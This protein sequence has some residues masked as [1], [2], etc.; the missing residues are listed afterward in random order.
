MCSISA[1]K[2]F[3][4]FQILSRYMINNS[5][6]YYYYITEFVIFRCIFTL[7]NIYFLFI[8]SWIRIAWSFFIVYFCTRT[9]SLIKFKRE[10]KRG[11]V[12][13]LGHRHS[14]IY[15]WY[16]FIYLFVALVL[17][18]CLVVDWNY[19]FKLHLVRFNRKRERERERAKGKKHIKQT[20]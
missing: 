3:L 14:G 10:K 1:F 4:Y 2:I 17:F 20:S 11:Q 9:Y 5:T 18:I 7:V 19:N 12:L 15:L 16:L 13:F 6:F 8:C